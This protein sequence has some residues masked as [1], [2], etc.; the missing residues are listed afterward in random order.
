MKNAAMDETPLYTALKEYAA[1]DIAHFDV[2]G[3]KKRLPLDG[4]DPFWSEIVKYDANSTKELDMLSNPGGI[5][6]K[7]EKLM[8]QAYGADEA[9][10]LVNGSTFGV[11]AMI[12]AAC[13][14]KEKIILPRNIHKSAINGV[15][16]SGSIPIFIE[17]EIDYDYGIANGLTVESVKKVLA[18]HNDAK[19]LFIV[20]PTYYGAVSDMSSIIKLC[21]AHKV[22][23]LVDEAHGAHFPFY[24]DFPKGAMALGADM[25]AVSLH[26]TGGSLT[27]SSVLLFNRGLYQS[28]QVRTAIN[29]MQTTSASYLLLA[30]LDLARKNLAVQGRQRFTAL[31]KYIEEAKREI[32][33]IPGMSVLDRSCINGAGIYDYDETKFVIKVNALGLSGFE[34]YDMLKNE[35]NVQAE[36]AETYVVLAIAAVGDDKK[37]LDRLVDA[38]RG[39][40]KRFWG[41]KPA[42]IVPVADFFEKPK[43][44]I[45]PREAYFSPAKV[46]P[47]SEAVGEISSESIMIYPPG[48]PLIVPGE[49]ITEKVVAHYEFYKTQHCVLMSDEERSGFIKVVRE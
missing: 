39:I 10:M 38:L 22:A 30:S 2:P 5:I 46:L 8:A 6:A 12:L 9:Y 49:R 18:E 32:N 43:A 35:Y 17:P 15:I 16:L 37:T 1:E 40:S 24:P 42:F 34:A 27:Q 44:V 41:K 19:A 31:M 14:P 11:Q 45:P 23:V 48:I 25:S 20:H 7:A 36:L 13:G 3:H 47:L 21:H 26:K 4:S 33:S 28:H 29:L